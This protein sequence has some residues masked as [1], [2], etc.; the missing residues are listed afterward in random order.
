MTAATELPSFQLPLGAYLLLE[1]RV[2]E[3]AWVTV[4]AKKEAIVEHHVDGP[5]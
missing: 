4:V 2:L 5:P 1:F 3:S